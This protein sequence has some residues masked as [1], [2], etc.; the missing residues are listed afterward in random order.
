MNEQ[1]PMDKRYGSSQKE[2][3]SKKIRKSDLRTDSAGR[4]DNPLSKFVT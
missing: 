1:G 4:S 3:M 2:L